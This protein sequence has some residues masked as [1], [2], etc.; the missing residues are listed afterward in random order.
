[1]KKPIEIFREWYEENAAFMAGNQALPGDPSA[2]VLATSSAEGRVSARMVLLKE[3]SNDNFVFFTNYNSLKALQLSSNSRAALLFWWPHLQRQIRIEGTVLR[4]LPEESDDYF[5][6]RPAESRLGAWASNQS[7]EIKSM[8][9]VK[10]RMERFR[11]KY[12][13]DIPRP[14]HW[15]GYRL[16]AER[17]EFWQEGEHRLHNRL[18]YEKNYDGWESLLL[19][20]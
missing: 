13:D 16:S 8:D 6:T 20:P 9:V 2:V 5:S 1:M 17:Y 15:G 3:F 7:D 10:R 14:R 12:G 11:E 19:A 18:V 4:T